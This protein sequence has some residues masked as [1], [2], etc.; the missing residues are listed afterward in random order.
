MQLICLFKNSKRTSQWGNNSRCAKARASLYRNLLKLTKNTSFYHFFS[1]LKKSSSASGKASAKDNVLQPRRQ[2][3]SL[4]FHRL[5]PQ[6]SVYWKLSVVFSL[7]D[8]SWEVK[9]GVITAFVE[10]KLKLWPY[11]D[12]YG[13]RHSFGHRILLIGVHHQ[14]FNFLM[15][16]RKLKLEKSLFWSRENWSSDHIKTGIVLVFPWATTF[17]SL[18]L[19]FTILSF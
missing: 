4:F 18:E 16:F 10:G 9:I 7:S 8:A 2:V 6:K 3:W 15:H 19:F 11:K 5:R 17:F 14:D 13:L 12:L 1:I